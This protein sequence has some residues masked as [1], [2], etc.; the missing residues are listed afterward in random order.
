MSVVDYVM[1]F[2]V[3]ISCAKT[4]A[5]CGG[6]VFIGLIECLPRLLYLQIMIGTKWENKVN[7]LVGSL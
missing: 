5:W 2:C 3:C 1:Y 7:H 4:I 6:H